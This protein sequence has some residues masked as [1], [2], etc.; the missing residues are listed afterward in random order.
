MSKIQCKKQ[1]KEFWPWNL[2]SQ[3]FPTRV[4]RVFLEKIHGR[5]REV[6][7]KMWSWSTDATNAAREEE[8]CVSPGRERPFI[9]SKMNAYN[10]KLPRSDAIAFGIP[11]KL[12]TSS[13]VDWCLSSNTGRPGNAFPQR[14]KTFTKRWTVRC[15]VRW[16]RW[17]CI[18][19]RITDRRGIIRTLRTLYYLLFF[20]SCY[21]L[22]SRRK[23][24]RNSLRRF[25]RFYASHLE[26]ER[27]KVIRN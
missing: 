7:P 25:H 5:S 19:A 18:G 23:I 17:S 26:R 27:E 9:F 22:Q 15:F 4:S 2:Q 14:V 3:F 10:S 21:N 13:R 11:C 8:I 16:I 12:E 6:S 1:C 20:P 24:S